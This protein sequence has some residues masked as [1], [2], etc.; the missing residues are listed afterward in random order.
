MLVIC[1]GIVRALSELELVAK[2]SCAIS[3]GWKLRVMKKGWNG[4]VILINLFQFMDKLLNL[5]FVVVVEFCSGLVD[6]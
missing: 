4:L 1:H 6:D 5:H 3:V 2:K